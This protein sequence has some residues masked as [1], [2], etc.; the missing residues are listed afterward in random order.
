[1]GHVEDLL[2]ELRR[3]RRI[4]AGRDVDEFKKEVMIAV[5]RGFARKDEDRYID[6]L[7]EEMRLS[8]DGLLEEMR[9]GI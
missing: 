4:F 1:M 6:G 3:V 2:E 8:T 5:Y 9:M 7:L